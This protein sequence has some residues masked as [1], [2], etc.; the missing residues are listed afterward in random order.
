[1]AAA[2]APVRLPARLRPGDRVAVL[3]PSSPFPQETFDAGLAVLRDW[4]LV[5]Q[6]L[7][8][9][10][11]GPLVYLAGAD[12]QRADALDRALR[13]GWACALWCARGGYGAGRLLDL[14]DWRPLR[15][16]PR[17]IVGF[18]DV[19]VLHLAALVHARVGGVH[20]PLLTTLAGSTP[21]VREATR[22]LLLDGEAPVLRAAAGAARAAPGVTP[23]VDGPLLVANLATLASL[24]GTR[25]LPSLDGWIVLLE[26]VHE[27]AYR[28]DRMLTQLVRAGV[29]YGV[30]GVAIGDFSGVRAADGTGPDAADVFQDRLTALAVPFAAGFSVGH[31]AA[32]EPAIIGA[33]YA[34]DA[35]LGTLTPLESLAAPDPL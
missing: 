27:R 13:D 33:R 32:N 20:A 2:P 16:R 29:L 23:R 10:A 9:P 19:S 1:V 21:A 15:A 22:R 3:A 34:F 28:V 17:A 5:P 11:A 7:V 12:W 4:G 30:A 18:S 26:D 14:L 6:P 31:I 25:D 8:H 24:V 35:E